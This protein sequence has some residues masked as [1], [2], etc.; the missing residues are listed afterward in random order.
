MLPRPGA[1]LVL[2]AGIV[3]AAAAAL[4]D[5]RPG[6][7]GSFGLGQAIALC[8][9]LAIAGLGYDLLAGRGADW[10]ESLVAA[11]ASALRLVALAVQLALLL[12]V[13]RWFQLENPAFAGIVVP[14]AAVGFVIHHLLPQR[15][16]LTYFIA[17][18]VI[19]FVT[20]L[21]WVNAAWVLGL[22]AAF[23]ALCHVRLPWLGRVAVLLA[24]A[25]LLGIARARPDWT[26]FPTALWPILGSILMFRLIVYAYDV[27]N[28]KDKVPAKWSLAY[29]FL[30]P[31][32]VF[33]LFPVIDFATFR[34]AYYDRE[35]LGIYQRGID[36]MARGVVHLLLYRLVYQHF[37]IA[38][39]DVTTGAQLVQSMIAT[40][41]LYLRVS[42]TFHF[43][44][45]MLHLFGFRLPETHRFFYLASSFADFWR[46]INIYW[47][48]FMMK[49]VFYPVYFPLRKRGET[50]ALVIATLSVFFITWLTHSYQWFWILGKWLFSWTDALFWAILGVFLVVNSLWEAKRGRKR[51]LPGAA[52]RTATEALGTA[53]KAVLVF[54]TICTLWSLW[55][56]ATLADWFDLMRVDRFAAAD[57]AAVLSVLGLV[58]VAAFIG[59]LTGRSQGDADRAAAADKQPWGRIALVTGGRL[60]AIALVTTPFVL[61]ELPGRVQQIA[62]DLRVPE[63]NKSDAAALQRGYYENLQGVSLKNSQLW[64]LFAQRPA[65]GRDIWRSGVLRERDDFLA[66]DMKAFFGIFERGMSFRTNRW[67]MRDRDYALDKPAGTRRIAVLGQSYVAGDGVTDGETFDELVENQLAGEGALPRTE[68]LNFG[69]GS[70][71]MLQQ[72]LLLEDRVWKFSPDIVMVVANHRDAARAAAH[73]VLQLNRGVEAPFPEVRE[74]LARAQVTPG[75]SE[76]EAFARMRP[77]Q[78]ALLDWTHSEIVR[79]ARARGAL[80]VWVYLSTPERGPTTKEIDRLAGA[81]RAAGFHVL[82]W[83]DVYDGVDPATLRSS[84]WDFHPNAAGHRMIARRLYRD[85]TADPALAPAR[86]ASTASPTRTTHD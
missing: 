31:N 81:A 68:I 12:F 58:G 83:A 66:R 7:T 69:I 47:K 60:G 43:I 13:T 37:T 73:A 41:L 86:A 61:G 4:A 53:A 67:G 52:R 65:E 59:E 21:G 45:G 28:A 25:T 8:A 77:H 35:A 42:G 55:S 51:A 56:S 84:A 27:R 79:L 9:A 10:M 80:P 33:P 40:F 34:R 36:W 15:L 49:V 30:L 24:A 22:T 78:E 38:P 19:G 82:N 1:A 48:D 46:R 2:L 75:L 76:T 29:F 17:L 14:L 72:L 23:A 18:S 63:L 44:I 85:L 64:E 26:P 62:R 6:T 39:S 50:T 5:L 57:W 3:L 71:S 32:V 74:A 70:Y 54:A 16:R 11:R 20:V